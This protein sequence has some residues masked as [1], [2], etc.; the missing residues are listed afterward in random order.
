MKKSISIVIPVFN[1]TS[2]LILMVDAIAVAM[3]TLP[4]EYKVIFVNDGSTDDTLAFL[5]QLAA[6]NKKLHYISF[7]RNFGHQNA[8]KAG[9]DYSNADAVISM[10]GDMQ[11]PPS[12]IPTLLKHWEDGK[13]IVYTVR[14]EQDNLPV[15]KKQTSNLFYKILNNLSS[16]EL[17]KGT[18]DFRLLDKKVVDVLKD[19]KEYDLF[20]RGLVKWVGYKQIAIEYTPAERAS[21]TS[22]YT[23]KKMME[24]AIKGITSFSTKPL[25]IAIYIGFFSS[26]LSF[27]YV[28]YAVVSYYSGNSISGWA[29]VIVT[30]AFFG[31]LQLMI[32]G[33]LGVYLGKLFMQNKERPHY[34]ISETNL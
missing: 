34:I 12:L 30:I 8:L 10:D 11:H 7:S 22:K 32:I 14:K 3:Q 31:G 25:T 21:G 18:A 4:Y 2:N 23:V 27:L 28:P 20:W 6:A 33:I 19:F 13:E 29:S 15:L 9:L 26:L 5:K 17:E 1:E 24:L 16:I